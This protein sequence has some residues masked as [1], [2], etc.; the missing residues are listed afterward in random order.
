MDSFL[1][2]LNATLPIFL[3]ILL[4]WFLRRVGLLTPAFTNVANK[5]VFQCA[6]PFSLFRSMSSMDFRS[7][8]DPKFCLF[9]FGVTTVM[10]F[11]V[12]GISWLAL[13]N[14]ALVGAFAQASVRSSAAILGIAMAENIY[15]SAGMVPMMIMA[16]VPFFNAYSVVIL[17]F[18]PHVDENGQ[19]IP[20]APEE[21]LWKK[22]LCNVA[23]NPIIIAILLGIPFSLFSIPIPTLAQTFI[24]QVAGSATTIALLV[25]GATFTGLD[26]FRNWKPTLAATLIKLFLLPALFLP[27]AAWF[28]FRNSA[29]IAILI[30]VGGPTTVSCFV[31]AKQMGGDAKL[32]AQAVALSTLVSSLSITLWVFLL[33]HFCLI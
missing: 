29:L 24:S 8:F 33:H 19:L 1:F 4:G 6:L 20:P 23:K 14:R 5:Y 18:S 17:T 12:W 7:E 26:S 11:G 9:C 15:G 30:M 13:K 27:L 22:T 21:N 3:V 16:S 10:F 25:V 32:T 31:M 28:G 2:A